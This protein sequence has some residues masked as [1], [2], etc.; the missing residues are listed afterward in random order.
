MTFMR[1]PPEN[2]TSVSSFG[3]KHGIQTSRCSLINTQTAQRNLPYLCHYTSINSLWQVMWPQDPT[4]SWPSWG[5]CCPQSPFPGWTNPALKLRD[6]SCLNGQWPLSGIW[7]R[8]FQ[9]NE[10]AKGS[11]EM[12]INIEVEGMVGL[13]RLRSAGCYG[14]WHQVVPEWSTENKGTGLVLIELL[15]APPEFFKIIFLIV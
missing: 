8:Q 12:Q 13:V 5:T 11:C 14:Q 7:A 1:R 6:N 9:E 10:A 15:V 4:C 2:I 3:S